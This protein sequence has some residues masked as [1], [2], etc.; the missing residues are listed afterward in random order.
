MALATYSGR[1]VP[2]VAARVSAV[3]ELWRNPIPPGWERGQDSRLLD[4]ATR[5][6]RGNYRE[7]SV[8]RGEHAIEYEVLAPSP[9]DVMTTSLGARLVDGVNAV[10]L[11]KDAGGGRTGNVEADMLLLVEDEHGYSLHLVEVKTSSNNPWFAAVENLRQLR[12]FSESHHAQRLF[13]TR[14]RELGLP[15]DLPVTAIVLAS[16]AFYSAPG[17]KAN[18][19][20]AAQGLL[21]RMH[22]EVNVDARL[23]VWASDVRVIAPYTS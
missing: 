8:R 2:S 13:H 10:P 6:G 3:V 12:L 7:D 1:H 21:A 22:A 23:A 15:Q 17:Q 18:S 14:C 20:A 11:A 19:L 5:Y 9:S 4:S 16:P